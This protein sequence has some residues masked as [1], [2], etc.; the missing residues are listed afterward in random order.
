MNARA[1]IFLFSAG[2][3]A[4]Q[5]ARPTFEV[6]SVKA[7]PNCGMSMFGG[8]SGGRLDLPCVNLRTLIRIAYG[9]FTGEKLNARGTN[10]TGGPAWLDSETYQITAKAAEKVSAAILMGPMLQMLLEER[11]QLK[12]HKEAKDTP[13]YILSAVKPEKLTLAKEG[14]CVPIDLNNMPRPTPG[15]PMPKYCGGGSISFRNGAQIADLPG[16]TMEEFAGRMLPGF[17]GRPVV[18]KTGLAGR[19][20]I[21]LE[22][23]RDP[24]AGPMM[25][26][27]APMPPP[28]E[29]AAPSIFTAV[30]EQLGLKLVPDRAPVEVIVVDSAQKPS[31]N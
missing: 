20:D 29:G 15:T 24:T 5:S 26:N 10:V 1:V 4:A 9:G 6:A 23:S 19:Y 2:I 16:V 30:Q 7:A 25:L 27:G 12:V 28:P 14:S 31:E 21:H 17:A 11:F 22:F 13:V 8:P 18:D 3:L